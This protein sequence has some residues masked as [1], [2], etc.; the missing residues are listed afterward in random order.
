[1]VFIEELEAI[2]VESSD[3]IISTKANVFLRRLG[4]FYTIFALCVALRLLE[5]I[6]R[7][8]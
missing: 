1:M 5:L 4:D 6:D 2:E 3:E 8:S 7:F